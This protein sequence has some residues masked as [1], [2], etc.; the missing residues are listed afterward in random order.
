MVL[1]VAYPLDGVSETAQ[2]VSDTWVEMCIR[3]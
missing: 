1:V 2:P 3:S